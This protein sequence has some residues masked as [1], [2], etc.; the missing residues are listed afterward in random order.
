MIPLPAILTQRRIS[1]LRVNIIATIVLVVLIFQGCGGDGA[2]P[3]PASSL[4]PDEGFEEPDID[5]CARVGDGVCLDA[6][7]L[8]G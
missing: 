6:G 5:R 8:E 4:D 3:C 1:P 2:Q 7:S